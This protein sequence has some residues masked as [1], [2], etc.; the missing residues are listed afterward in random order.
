MTLRSAAAWTLYGIG[1][2]AWWLECKFF[3]YLYVEAKDPRREPW[4]N[5]SIYPVYNRLMVWA[6]EIQGPSGNGPWSAIVGELTKGGE[7]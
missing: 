3:G 4:F 6:H 2:A 1:C 7:T 5:L